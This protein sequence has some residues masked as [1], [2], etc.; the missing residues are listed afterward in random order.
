[1]R[2]SLYILRQHILPFIYGLALVIFLFVLNLL[3][4]MLGKVAG[5]GIP[6]SIMVEYFGLSMGWILVLAIPMAVLIATLSTYG[7]L[8]GDGEV[9]A[10]RALGV[11]P[12]Q[13]IAPVVMTSLVVAFF[14]AWFG[15]EVLPDMNHRLKLLMVDI[16]RKRPTLTLEPGIYNFTLP[17][18]VLQVK[19]V[20]A[21][22]GHLEEITIYDERLGPD[23]RSVI[24]ARWGR[25]SFAPE[26][27]QVIMQLY[28]G[29]IHRHSP[30]EPGGYE[31]TSFDSAVF[32]VP[33]P[34]MMLRREDS[35][36]RSDRE[37][38]VAQLRERIRDLRS[39]SPGGIP[40]KR[41]IAAYAVEIHKKFAIPAASVVLVLVGAPI[42]ILA[43]RG[44]I[45]VAGGIGLFFFTLYWVMLGA[46]ED[47][48]DRL[49]ISPWIAMWSP[50]G[51]VAL[52]GLWAWR[53][54]R[55]HTSF[56]G[57]HWVKER[58]RRWRGI[59]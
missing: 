9:T 59:S 41:R 23:K 48:A 53:Y 3:F 13:M 12:S 24:S 26:S 43:R 5:K 32:R 16:S 11:S 33:A 18:Y 50:N 7:R 57:A 22:G 8:A 14:V 39:Q 4:Q 15:N 52:F 2:L 10:L 27:E 20:E 6:I 28:Q 17:Q 19:K 44:G 45:G 58:W 35:G 29:E 54:A 46:G 25:I 55:Y 36:Y 42:G 56:P 21:E 1:M 34:D 47:L 31:Q 51:I 49:I 40:D 30:R 37:L 38:S